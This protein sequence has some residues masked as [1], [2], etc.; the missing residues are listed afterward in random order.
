MAWL[1]GWSYRKEI[2]VTG[3]SGAG[4]NFQ[5]DLDMG[6]SAGGDFHLEGHCTNFPQDIEVTD[7]DETTPIDYWIEDITADPLKMWVEVADDLG[8]NQTIYVYYGKS[9][10]TTNSSGTNTFI[11]YHG[12][13]TATFHDSNVVPY[14]NVIYEAKVKSVDSVHNLIF[15]L[16]SIDLISTEHAL[17]I[18]SLNP[19]GQN[20]RYAYAVDLSGSTNVNET[21]SFVVDQWYQ[22]KSIC[23]GTNVKGYVDDDQ[24][25]TTITTNL[26]DGNMGLSMY[27]YTGNGEQDWSFAHKYN[28]PEPAFSSAGSEE[29]PPT[30]VTM[31][32]FIH[33]QNQMRA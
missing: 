14:T 26:P 10:A 28:S 25:G 31:P 11:Q 2:S 21:G 33:H 27:E 7:N 20:L 17:K 29:T 4:T 23:D 24:I 30:G 32:L 3:Q 18:L 15:G 19:E 16:A 13:A 5:V 9:G 1:S 6:D 22:I 12:A 8:S